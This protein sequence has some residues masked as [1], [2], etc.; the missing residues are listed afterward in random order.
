MLTKVVVTQEM[1]DK[2]RFARAH[3]ESFMPSHHCVMALAMSE[4]RGK[5][6]ISGTHCWYDK[7]SEKEMSKY[8]TGVSEY[9]KC[10]DMGVAI[11]PTEFM[12]DI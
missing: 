8:P 10:F 1:I 6:T 9:I 11:E 12:I 2:A 7:E 3:D 5:D 4:V